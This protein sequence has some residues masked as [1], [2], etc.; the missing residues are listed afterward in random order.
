MRNIKVSCM[1]LRC[2][3][4]TS[5]LVIAMSRVQALTDTGNGVVFIPSSKNLGIGYILPTRKL[6]VNGSTFTKS[7]TLNGSALSLTQGSLLYSKVAGSAAMLPRGSDHYALK[8]NGN[9]LAWESAASSDSLDGIDSTSFLRS[10]TS[11]NYTFGTLTLNAGTTFDINSTA[12]SIADTVIDFDGTSTT[13]NG[14]TGAMTLRPAAG[15]NLNVSLSTTGDFAV[16]TNQLYVDTSAANVGIGIIAPTSKLHV[17]GTT[18][19][20]GFALNGSALS[21]AQG[22]LLYSQVAGSAA[23]L[24]RGTNHYALKVNG[25]TLAW[26][27]D[28]LGALSIDDLSDAKTVT[29]SVFLGA[30]S[31]SSITSAIDNVA[32]GVGALRNTTTG[33][34][35]VAIGGTAL[36]MNISGVYNTAVGS[37]ALRNN[38]SGQWN[39][40][41]GDQSLV[42]NTS[43]TANTA[44]GFGAAVNNRIGLSNTGVGANALTYNRNG[45]YNTSI[46]SYSLNYPVLGSRNTGVGYKAGDGTLANDFSNGTFLGYQTGLNLT[47]GD[48]NILIGYQAG[49]SITSGSNNI[50]IGNDIDTSSASASNEINIGNTI[51]GNTSTNDVRIAND[52]QVDGTISGDGSDLTN[53]AAGS[54]GHLQF[55]TAGALASNGQLFWRS[56]PGLLG[57]GNSN[58]QYKL[59]VGGTAAAVVAVQNTFDETNW[60]EFRTLGI[61]GTGASVSKWSV[62]SFGDARSDTHLQNSFYIY[63][64]TDKNDNFIHGSIPTE[65]Q[66][67]MAINDNGYFAFG[68]PYM[69]LVRFDYPFNFNGQAMFNHGLYANGDIIAK[70]SYVQESEYNNTTDTID[71]NRGNQQSKTLGAP[72]TTL[73]FT[74]PSGPTR[75]VLILIQDGT[76]S[77]TVT[78]P[79]NVK[80]PSATAPTLTTTAGRID[81]I[82]CIYRSSPDLYL[83]VPS[84]DFTP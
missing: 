78:W 67:R 75:L 69:N 34:S 38:I 54:T 37:E 14:T 23:M 8:V 45:D 1:F 72:T 76:G 73:T 21:L 33:G 41:V 28:S 62:G 7:F 60:Q 49:D 55:N 57:V 18:F 29:D 81:V 11:D 6:D 65:G 59:H 58:P 77:R 42:Y 63:Q 27:T 17:N 32:V 80:W 53:I 50:I 43:G 40:A 70:K 79:A 35:N 22:S 25:N 26:E 39:T 48:N 15:T 2:V 19:T 68:Y 84:L 31:G 13:F 64:F 52:L 4:V 9:T 82:S 66:F 10:D 83:C 71:W 24:P 12:V 36:E 46:G 20:K 74:A 30:T 51:Y 5:C 61:N 3:L 44:L 47:T 56:D 16:N